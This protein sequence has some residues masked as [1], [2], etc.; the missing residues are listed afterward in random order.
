MRS[1]LFSIT[2][3][4]AL[5]TA[6]MPGNAADYGMPTDVAQTARAH[7]TRTF[8][9]LSGQDRCMQN[10]GRAFNR[11]N[12]LDQAESVRFSVADEERKARIR[13]ESGYR[14]PPGARPLH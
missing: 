11:L 2:V 9:T 10:E 7:C 4:G 3:A 5:M 1:A 6:A 14:D 13:N 8:D 12:G